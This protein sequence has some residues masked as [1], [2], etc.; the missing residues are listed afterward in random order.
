MVKKVVRYKNRNSW[1]CNDHEKSANVKIA[2]V[3][4]R[5]SKKLVLL[6]IN[7]LQLITS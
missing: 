5:K 1:S 7:V 2:C 4:L 6:I 3:P